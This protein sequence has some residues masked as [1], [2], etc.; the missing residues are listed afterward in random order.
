M[1]KVTLKIDGMMCGMCEAHINDVIRKNMPEAK[2]V[3]SSF[4]KGESTF[5]YE[6]T[7]DEEKLKEVIRE[8]GY[9]LKEISSE[10]YQKKWSLFG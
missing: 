10:S 9:E 2:K 3:S 4:K 5:L 1:N 7:V 8:T 6:G